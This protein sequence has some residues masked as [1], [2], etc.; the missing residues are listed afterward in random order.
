MTSLPDH[1]VC[2]AVHGRTLLEVAE[3]NDLKIPSG[4][5]MGMCGSDPLYIVEG[6]ENLSAVT[7]D[8]QDTL[9]RLGLSAKWRMACC[10]RV[11]GAVVASQTALEEAPNA[12]SPEPPDFQVDKG[13]QDVVIVGNGVAGAT[14]ADYIRRYHPDCNITIVARE[15]YHFYNRMAVSKLIDGGTDLDQI[16][17]TPQLWYQKKQIE[18]LL[19]S[20]VVRIDRD[21]NIVVTDRRRMLHY[22]RLLLAMGSE[23]FIPPIQGWGLSGTFAL[24]NIDDALGLR[25][26]ALFQSC[27]EAVV[28]GGG[29]LGLEAGHALTSLGLHVTVLVRDSSIL[30]RQLDPECAALLLQILRELHI[31]VLLN[32]ELAMILGDDK[33]EALELV[34]GRVL[35]CDLFLASVGVRPAVGLALDAALNVNR[36]VVV[37][38]ELR[39]SD[40]AIYA[41][42]D[43][44]EHRETLYGIWPASVEQAKVAAANLLGDHQS[45][46][47]TM[48]VTQLKVLGVELVSLGEFN[49]TGEDQVIQLI[50]PEERRYR[51]LVLNQGRIKGAILLGYPQEAMAVVRA[52]KDGLDM[53]SYVEDLKVGRWD[54]IPV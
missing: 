13:I 7:S 6:S 35:R 14:A 12:E 42:G 48:P 46:Q 28:L 49:G 53:S 25:D 41:A 17:L 26:F 1:L 2:L 31:E 44:V 20:E 34:D 38:D 19:G 22:D 52:A 47:G 8:E 45:Y 37:D 24:R 23:S 11:Q 4:C 33:V 43:L 10:A 27:Q 32:T 9:T 18:C 3:A 54:V 29:L 51:K 21:R 5:R 36:G 39:T 16:T 50:D 30:Q 15:P 40:M